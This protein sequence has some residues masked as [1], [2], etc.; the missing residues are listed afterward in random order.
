LLPLNRVL[1]DLQGVD[2]S[3]G[4]PV[5]PWILV[6]PH[7]NGTPS[8][9]CLTRNSIATTVTATGDTIAD[10]NLLLTNADSLFINPAQFDFHLR[11][12]F[13]GIQQVSLLNTGKKEGT[14]TNDKGDEK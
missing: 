9:D 14:L 8:Q 6:N 4:W 1:D 5:P 12:G 2:S 7:K 11:Y 10:Y 3:D 13:C